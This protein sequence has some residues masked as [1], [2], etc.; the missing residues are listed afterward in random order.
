MSKNVF[1]NNGEPKNLFRKSPLG[2]NEDNLCNKVTKD[3]I[4]NYSYTG[5]VNQQLCFAFT[6]RPHG[7][8]PQIT[9]WWSHGAAAVK[10][11]LKNKETHTWQSINLGT[12]LVN[13]TI[14]NN[15]SSQEWSLEEGRRRLSLPQPAA[16]PYA[17]WTR[18]KKYVSIRMIGITFRIRKEH[19]FTY[20]SKNVRTS[21]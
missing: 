2:N 12:F 3:D 20:M 15:K 8:S 14:S 19:T 1:F 9:E 10:E 21:H 6:N 5:S 7:L 17:A 11:E 4:H 13:I 16:A 18:Q